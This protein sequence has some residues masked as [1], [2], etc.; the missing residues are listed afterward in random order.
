MLNGETGREIS[1]GKDFWRAAASVRV[2]Y[3]EL[4]VGTCALATSS[5]TLPSPHTSTLT[6]PQYC[7]L[8]TLSIHLP[9]HQLGSEYPHPCSHSH[10]GS[11]LQFLRV[12]CARDVAA[13]FTW[14][15]YMVK[16]LGNVRVFWWIDLG[17]NFV[18]GNNNCL[19]DICVTAS[20]TLSFFCRTR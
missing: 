7:L 6:L 12:I 3:Q 16:F 5:T 13:W 11:T 18:P 1:M 19:R 4:V 14:P 17:E 9:T 20:R 2:Q 15:P 10:N 8:G